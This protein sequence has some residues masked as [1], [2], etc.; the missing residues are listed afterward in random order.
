[1]TNNIDLKALERKVYR[2]NFQDGLWDMFLGLLLF[3]TV[4]GMILYRLGWSE[5]LTMV[6]IL[7]YVLLVLAAFTLAKKYLITPRM[8]LVNFGPERKAKKKKLTLILSL[9]SLLGAVIFVAVTTGYFKLSGDIAQTPAIFV[10]FGLFAVMSV[11][12]FSLGAYLLDYS[13]AYLYGWFFG[14]SM[15]LNILLDEMFGI[16]FPWATAVF[17]AIMV[18]I[19]LV[20]FV[21]FMQTHPVQEM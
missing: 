19:G 5:V 11:I 8:G 15:P 13:R 16:T 17:S 10:P 3:Q 18:L 9:T 20:L 1:M 4:L 12:V 14:L 6:V 21:R 7:T 2:S